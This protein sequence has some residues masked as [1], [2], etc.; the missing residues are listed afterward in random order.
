MMKIG[1][2]LAQPP[3]Y[4]E[5]FF[6]SKIKGLTDKGFEVSLFVGANAKQVSDFKMYKA[7]PVFSNNAVGQIFYMMMAGIQL[8][9]TA[10]GNLLNFY[11]M[12]RAA[13]KSVKKSIESCY[14]NAHMLRK[15]L[16]WLHFGFTTLT[17]GKENVAKAIGAKMATSMR[18]FDVSIYPLKH[19]G[20]YDILWD[21]LDKL[22]VIS[23]DLYKI[24]L[25]LGL[26]ENVPVM[27]ITP[28][29]DA[30]K[31]GANQQLDIASKQRQGVV[32]ILTVA[33]L[34]WKK[35]LEYALA[36]M[37]ELK[38]NNVKF[39][40]SIV[41]DG[42]ELERLRFETNE[43]G[44]NQQVKFLGK[45]TPEEIVTLMNNHLIY[46][47]PSIQEG[48]CNAVLEAQASGLLCIVSDAEGLSENVLHLTTGWVTKKRDV[49]GMTDVIMEI[50]TS[51]SDQLEEITGKA[52]QRIKEE[53]TINHQIEQFVTFYSEN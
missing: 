13:G 45:K 38:K 29:I 2:V 32:K 44:L 35:G 15:K 10:P 53:F 39:E 52:K 50:L 11:K 41:G 26:S 24:G 17:V 18:G 22:H 6:R 31:F 46:L 43:Y 49:K 30:D 9:L 21:K 14:I 23:D 3:G 27:K 48:F 28:A 25:S 33:R 4:S 42:P 16:D 47:Q 8:L 20:V 34:H 5:T 37:A 36:V 51:P 12:E 7:W 1:L 19:P 40:Y